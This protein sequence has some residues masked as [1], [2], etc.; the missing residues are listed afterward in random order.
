MENRSLGK[1]L[2]SRVKVI[3][4]NAIAVVLAMSFIAYFIFETQYEQQIRATILEQQEQRQVAYAK[5][6]ANNIRSDLE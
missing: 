3:A 6:I 5:S 2:S 1:G 4:G